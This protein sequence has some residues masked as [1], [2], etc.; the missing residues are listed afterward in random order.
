[1]E[2]S[3]EGRVPLNALLDDERPLF[4][5]LLSVVGEL[6]T[7]AADLRRWGARHAAEVDGWERSGHLPREV[8]ADLGRIGAFRARWANGQRGG[9]PHALVLAAETSLVS[10]GLSLAV[11]LHSEI[12][13]GCLHRFGG[14]EA[15]EGLLRAALEGEVVGCFAATE[16]G[17]GSAIAATSTTATP[18]GDGWI[19]SGTKR[20]ISNAGSASHAIV[21]ARAADR[22][23]GRDLCLFVVPLSTVGTTVAGFFPKLGTDACDAAEVVF[24][25]VRLDSDALLC[26]PGVGMIGL[27]RILWF[28]RISVAAQLIT[29]GHV[30]V[31]MATAHLRRRH[32][33]GSPLV[34]MQALR[35][36]L[37][38]V[39]AELWACEALLDNVTRAVMAGEAAGAL[40]AALKL[41]CAAMAAT[42]VDECLQMLGGRGYTRNYPAERSL[43]DVRLARI[44]AGTD[45]VMRE[46]IAH[47]L[48]RPDP[49]VEAWLRMLDALDVAQ[50]DP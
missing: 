29:A 14:S 28:E 40:T 39:T 18:D 2:G 42:A 25:D 46:T 4:S 31:R 41:R 36:R 22:P 45:E 8:L 48:D 19:L 3:G 12:F 11:T 47:A 24:E 20:Y 32:Q 13:V 34:T 26:R 7:F 35:H 9:L 33:A 50:P 16:P 30:A 37:A 5:P 43:R 15:R 1:L 27:A 21:V 6:G 49:A 44:G 23:A 10:S 38:D 17:G